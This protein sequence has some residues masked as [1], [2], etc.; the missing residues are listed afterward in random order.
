MCCEQVNMYVS[1]RQC[2]LRMCFA[3]GKYHSDNELWICGRKV[4]DTILM[5]IWTIAMF[6]NSLFVFTIGQQITEFTNFKAS[7]KVPADD[8]VKTFSNGTEHRCGPLNTKIMS[9]PQRPRRPTS[10]WKP[11]KIKLRATRRHSRLP[12][13]YR[14][15]K[16]LFT[17]ASYVFALLKSGEGVLVKVKTLFDDGELAFAFST[18]E[19]M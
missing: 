16:Q 1:D 15:T 7:R 19:K 14:K 11:F 5:R 8:T 18:K 12:V 13:K 4:R 6:G 9:I 2:G 10:H 17:K 3:S